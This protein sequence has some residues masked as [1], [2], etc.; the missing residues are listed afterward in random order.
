MVRER[1]P[2]TDSQTEP[3]NSV[4]W[5]V[6]LWGHL[7]K[8][9]VALVVVSPTWLWVKPRIRVPWL[10]WKVNLYGRA[11]WPPR[12]SPHASPRPRPT[13]VYFGRASP[14]Y[15]SSKDA[16]R[17]FRLPPGV[18]FSTWAGSKAGE[19]LDTPPPRVPKFACCHKGTA[20]TVLTVCACSSTLT[21]PSHCVQEIDD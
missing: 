1:N 6:P 14:V 21:G 9:Q 17:T 8:K 10:T 13:P 15:F 12:G 4:C 11:P 18:T 16:T 7:R 5:E 2:K 3:H 20:M 19:V